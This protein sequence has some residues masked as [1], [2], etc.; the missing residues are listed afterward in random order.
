[1][2]SPQT[3]INLPFIEAEEDRTARL[4]W[5]WI[6]TFATLALIAGTWVWLARAPRIISVESDPHGALILADGK[7]LGETP[8]RNLRI[9]QGVRTLHLEKKGYVPLDHELRPEEKELKLKLRPAPFHV[10]VRSEPVGAQVFLDGHLIGETPLEDL[11]IPGEGIHILKVERSGH[12]SWITQVRADHTLPDPIRLQKI[13]SGKTTK[14]K[15]DEPGK[16]KKFFSN[17]FKRK[18]E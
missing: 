9:G 6:G 7:A 17:L 13:S 16:V 18:K 5:I 4:H 8:L 12:V 11:E 3:P 1:M 2:A 14:A 10:H 15:P